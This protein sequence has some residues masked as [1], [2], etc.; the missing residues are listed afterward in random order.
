[1]PFAAF[2]KAFPLSQCWRCRLGFFE[3]SRGDEREITISLFFFLNAFVCTF[4]ANKKSSCKSKS[5]LVSVKRFIRAYLM[6]ICS[7]EFLFYIHMYITAEKYPD[8]CLFL[9]GYILIRKLRINQ[10]AMVL[11]FIIII[12]TYNMP[13]ISIVL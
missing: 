4:F 1:M 11:F 9:T 2:Q 12:A 6:E 8:T 7:L 3:C 13:R 10:S 5:F